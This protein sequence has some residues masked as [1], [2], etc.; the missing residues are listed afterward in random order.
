[1]KK[2]SLTLATLAVAAS[3]FAQTP[4]QPQAPAQAPATTAAASAPSAEQRAARHEARI[5]Q[6]IKYLHDQLKIT[7][8][9]EPQWKTFAD[10]MRDNGATM[11]RLYSERMAKHDVSAL[12]D[13]KQYAELSQ[14]NADGAKKL[15]DA[16]APL[17][18]SFPAEQKALADTTFRSWLHHGGEHRGKGKAK[19]KEGKA[20]AAPA[21]SAPA[22]P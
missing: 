2:I 10:T 16:F 15:A 1:M 14:A 8:A 21:A 5:E 13:M 12:D 3:A 4:A 6:R 18:E 22:Q 20:A 17:Y 11:G 7:S 19:G 9:Q